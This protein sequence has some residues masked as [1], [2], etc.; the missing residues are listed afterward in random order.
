MER[1]DFSKETFIW[2]INRIEDLKKVLKKTNRVGIIT[3]KAN[4]LDRYLKH[5]A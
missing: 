2:T 3:D 4:L 5:Q 1:W